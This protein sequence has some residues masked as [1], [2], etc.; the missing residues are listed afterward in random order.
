MQHFRDVKGLQNVRYAQQQ[1]DTKMGIGDNEAGDQCRVWLERQQNRKITTKKREEVKDKGDLWLGEIFQVVSWFVWL[2]AGK[3]EAAS[4]NSTPSF[5]LT[6]CE[7]LHFSVWPISPA[8]PPAPS[9]S[10]RPQNSRH[11]QMAAQPVSCLRFTQGIESGCLLLTFHHSKMRELRSILSCWV[12]L[13]LLFE[14]ELWH[15]SEDG[16][17]GVC[18]VAFVTLNG[19][20]FAFPLVLSSHLR[21]TE[22]WWQGQN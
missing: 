12:F 20:R 11:L 14:Q 21:I 16:W 19:T 8:C 3:A 9:A 5:L 6:A 17:K 4:I 22:P 2:I 1:K 15:W 13:L 7:A 10:S 18:R